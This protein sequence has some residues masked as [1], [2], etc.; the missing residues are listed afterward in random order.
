VYCRGACGAP[1][2]FGGCPLCRGLRVY[3]RGILLR[4]VNAKYLFES[5]EVDYLWMLRFG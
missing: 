2:P 3:T 4:A 1:L 5:D